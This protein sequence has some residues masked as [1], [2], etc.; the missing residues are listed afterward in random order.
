MVAVG[1][2]S[3][4]LI[5]VESSRLGIDTTFGFTSVRLNGACFSSVQSSIL[6]AGSAFAILATLFGVL[7]VIAAILTTFIRF[8]PCF[9]VVMSIIA[10]VVAVLAAVVAGIGFADDACA[11]LR[12]VTCTP[13]PMM[14]VVMVGAVFWL[15]AGATFL[16]LRGHER[17]GIMDEDV[18]PAT[19]IAAATANEVEPS[20]DTTVIETTTNPDGTKTRTTTVT[21]HKEG[22]IFV[23]KTNETV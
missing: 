18:K 19:V 22:Q 6:K 20:N 14:Y 10:F 21:T 17:E 8:P 23:E 1:G 9:I 13:G 16:F 2:F 15:A 5:R 4:E 3:C 12:S 7:T 11:R